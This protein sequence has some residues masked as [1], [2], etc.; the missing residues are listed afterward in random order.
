M[1]HKKRSANY[2]GCANSQI[3]CSE[4]LLGDA[5]RFAPRKTWYYIW[6]CAGTVKSTAL[7]L[8]KNQNNKTHHKYSTNAAN[9][10]IYVAVSAG[11]RQAWEIA[12]TA[13]GILQNGHNNLQ[14]QPDSECAWDTINL[15]DATFQ[16]P[17][18]TS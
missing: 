9:K 2:G 1:W 16:P 4:H 3:F 18:S 11:P 14:K 15:S 7:K 13:Y 8:C 10:A 12:P 17:P 6:R 5:V